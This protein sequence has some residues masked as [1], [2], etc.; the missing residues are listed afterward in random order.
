MFDKLEKIQW[1]A[2][3]IFVLLFAGMFVYPGL[4]TQTPDVP[5]P[6]K[7]EKAHEHLEKLSDP[8]KQTFSKNLIKADTIVKKEN[9]RNVQVKRDYIR[10]HPRIY[11][12]VRDKRNALKQLRLIKGTQN[13]KSKSIKISDME[14]DSYW[15]SLGFQEND[16]IKYLDGAA[17]P[18]T[19]EDACWDL[20]NQKRETLENGGS[21]IITVKRGGQFVQKVFTLDDF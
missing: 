5:P 10:V 4:L 7:K 19:D 12:M 15:P 16:E 11:D 3:I 1:I 2:I 14:Q 9:G 8:A 18:F 13:L 17:I 6:V 20:Y 21:I